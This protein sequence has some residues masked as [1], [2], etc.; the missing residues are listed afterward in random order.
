[1]PNVRRMLTQAGEH[2]SINKEIFLETLIP[3]ESYRGWQLCGSDL[4]QNI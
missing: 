4:L 2:L 1:V 3:C